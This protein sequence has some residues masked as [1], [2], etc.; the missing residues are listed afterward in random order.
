[1]TVA[2]LPQLKWGVVLTSRP[3]PAIFHDADQGISR[4]PIGVCGEQFRGEIGRRP[5][6]RLRRLARGDLV[7]A[8]RRAD[9]VVSVTTG[10]HLASALT[11]RARVAMA[12]DEQRAE[13]DA[14]DALACA[15][16]TG[17]YQAVPDMHSGSGRRGR[18]SC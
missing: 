3:N 6:S 9:D 5:L 13:R 8:R 2:D 11:T 12:Q 16:A 15:A 4:E 1:M 17:S 18:Q 10:W 7:S 14:Y